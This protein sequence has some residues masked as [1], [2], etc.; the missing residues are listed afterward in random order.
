MPHAGNKTMNVRASVLVVE[1]ETSLRTPMCAALTL[2]GFITHQAESVDDALRILGAEH[3]DALVLDVR[4]P[5]P[6]GQQKTGLHLLRFVRATPEHARLPVLVFTGVPLSPAEE[7]MVRLNGGKV[8][9]KPQ[10]YAVLI[11]HLNEL[12]NTPAG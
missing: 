11:N 1:D 3:V 12:L 2:M 7:E 8:F 6:S 5:D 10:P 4:L 9:Y